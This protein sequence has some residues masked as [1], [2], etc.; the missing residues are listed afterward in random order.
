M[1][2]V[3][4]SLVIIMI[5]FAALLMSFT[6]AAKV[7]RQ[8]SN[9]S[10]ADDVAAN[11]IE[12]V[13]AMGVEGF[14]KYAHSEGAASH[15]EYVDRNGDFV[16][17][18]GDDYEVDGVTFSKG[19][20]YYE[21]SSIEQ[22]TAEYD[23][24]VKIRSSI[25]R[26][27]DDADKQINEHQYSDFSAFSADTSAYVYPRTGDS[28]VVVSGET[29]EYI[30]Y[31]D[32]ALSFFKDLNSVKVENEF[33]R[34]YE[35]KYES[36]TAAMEYNYNNSEKSGFVPTPTVALPQ[37]DEFSPAS[38]EELKKTIKRI[39]YVDI[40]VNGTTNPRTGQVEGMGYEVSSR[41][42]YVAVNTENYYYQAPED[43]DTDDYPDFDPSDPEDLLE[44]QKKTWDIRYEGYCTN[45][46]MSDLESLILF[47]TP[48]KGTLSGAVWK[49]DK[50]VVSSDITG[51]TA[52]DLDFYIPL[53][54]S[55]Q[56]KANGADASAL[57]TVVEDNTG[58][59]LHLKYY[60]QSRVCASQGGSD[61][62][63]KGAAAVESLIKS[64]LGDDLDRIFD[65][66]VEVY[67]HADSDGD[68][69]KDKMATLSTTF[70]DSR[71]LK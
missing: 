59:A 3:I 2:E 54:I 4:V 67:T 61:M 16:R 58:S 51:G 19:D 32:K 49:G 37:R 60:S 12:D 43:V 35:S 17:Y 31:D 71:E 33:L 11:V 70:V 68:K 13:K 26:D 29:D 53:Q 28:T 46:Y 66:T 5:I 25:Y 23:V 65:V 7:N 57:E 62:R 36:N 18:S 30:G 24:K 41:V 15:S 64:A 56:Q 6:T 40:T 27:N 48:L 44:L 10:Y 47:L 20:Y 9:M 42:E 22:G 55:G 1:I 34:D 50:V 69:W 38:D 14:A 45:V 52:R 63:E 39:V 8:T 21:F